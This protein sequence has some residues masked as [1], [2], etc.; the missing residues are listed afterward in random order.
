MLVYVLLIDNYSHYIAV[1]WLTAMLIPN[2]SEN[3]GS[4]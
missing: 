1:I 3:S 4:V 2:H